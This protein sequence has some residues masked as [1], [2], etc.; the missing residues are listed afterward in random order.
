MYRTGHNVGLAEGGDVAGKFHSHVESVY[1]ID[2]M[3]TQ[4]SFQVS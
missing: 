3:C 1:S 4:Y 2:L